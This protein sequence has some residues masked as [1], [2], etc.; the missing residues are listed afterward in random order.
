MIDNL[1]EKKITQYLKITT[2]IKLEELVK[3]AVHIDRD[4]AC[5]IN[6]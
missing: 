3:D 4:T 6:Q 5:S 1:M 2:I